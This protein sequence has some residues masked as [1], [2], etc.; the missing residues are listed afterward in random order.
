MIYDTNISTKWFGK[1]PRAVDMMVQ[2]CFQ[3]DSFLVAALSTCAYS[4]LTSA[5][6][7]HY[8]LFPCAFYRGSL[9][10]A[11]N[12]NTY[13]RRRGGLSVVENPGLS[14][15]LSLFFCRG[16]RSPE[17]EMVATRGRREHKRERREG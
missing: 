3:R 5:H 17:L 1:A 15:L 13:L 11:R 8:L 7:H 6:L 16:T 4:N 12:A 9:K 14:P 2:F 10:P